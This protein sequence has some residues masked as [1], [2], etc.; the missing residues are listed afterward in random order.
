MKKGILI[1]VLSVF[2]LITISSC[3]RKVTRID[4][5]EVIDISGRWND[6]DA[7][8]AAEELSSQIVM[9]DWI[10]D[11]MIAKGKKPVVIVG[12][13]RNKSHEHIDAEVFTVEVEKA[14]VKYQK[15]R[16]V[17]GGEMREELRAEKA[18]QQTNASVSTMKKFG[19]ETG[20]DFILQGTINSVVDALKKQKVVYYQVDLELTNIETNEKVWF[21]DKKIKKYI[22]N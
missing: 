10:N 21:G 11:Y 1:A 12:L 6:T 3:A 19:L 8:L 22:K 15:A 14:L 16:V 4:T 17:Q 7:R 18:D 9:G 2:G 13:V 5:N 20:A